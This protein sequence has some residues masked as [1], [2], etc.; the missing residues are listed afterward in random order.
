MYTLGE[1]KNMAEENYIE[2]PKSGKKKALVWLIVLVL[3]AGV[4]VG[5]YFL[6]TNLT[7]PTFTVRAYYG[8]ELV[9]TY[10]VKE[11]KSFDLS[12]ITYEGY[13]IVGIYDNRNLSGEPLSGS[14][15]ITEDVNLFLDCERLYNIR[16]TNGT[17]V[18]NV[19]GKHGDIIENPSV[20]VKEH[21]RFLG[22]AKSGEIILSP[23]LP[24]VIDT[25]EFDG[26]I[27]IL[28]AVWEEAYILSFNVNGGQQIEN[29]Y[30]FS[31]EELTLPMPSRDHYVFTGWSTSAGNILN[32]GDK[33]TLTENI[34]LTAS[35]RE[36]NYTITFDTKGNG[37]VASVQ[38]KYNATI[39]LPQVTQSGMVFIGW[40]YGSQIFNSLNQFTVPDLGDDNVV[41]TFVAYFEIEE[42]TINFNSDGGDVINPFEVKYQEEITLPVVSKEGY[43]FIGWQHNNQ[44]YTGKYTVQDLGEDDASVTFKALWQVE[45]YTISFDGLG[46]QEFEDIQVT[47]GENWD[48]PDFPEIEG[49]NFNGWKLNNTILTGT[50]PDLGNDGDEFTA[51]ADISIKSYIFILNLNGGHFEDSSLVQTLQASFGDEITFPAAVRD[52]YDFMGWGCADKTF[53]GNYIVEDLDD[54]ITRNPNT[55][56]CNAIWKPKTVILT[57]DYGD[58]EV[59]SGGEQKTMSFVVGTSQDTL[60]KP[61]YAEPYTFVGW[62]TSES[63]YVSPVITSDMTLYAIVEEKTSINA[64]G[65]GTAEDPYRIYNSMQLN[66]LSLMGTADCLIKTDSYLKFMQ[67]MEIVRY[68]YSAPSRE[69]NWVLYIDGNDTTLTLSTQLFNIFGGEISNLNLKFNFSYTQDN[70]N[71]FSFVINNR[72]ILDNITILQADYNLS[73]QQGTRFPYANTALICRTNEGTISNCVNNANI[74]ISAV[75]NPEF[76][77]FVGINEGLITNC[78]NHGNI[79]ANG[80]AKIAVFAISNE[81]D[82]T[83]CNSDGDITAYRAGVI[84]YCH[85]T[86]EIININ[87]C[88]ISGSININGDVEKSNLLGSVYKNSASKIYINNI[89]YSYDGLNLIAIVDVTGMA[90]DLTALITDLNEI[91]SSCPNVDFDSIIQKS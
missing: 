71:Y 55:I 32:A 49:Y 30:G 87:N 73:I 50:V 40:Q 84:A 25:A 63:E 65:S 75:K 2:K 5:L 41:V 26:Y 29:L 36:E 60:P 1:D 14:I 24:Y 58:K 44:T 82:I 57:F 86:S 46:Y 22:W 28:T 70:N 79:N 62:S 20:P 19:Y 77:V 48:L 69:T 66:G 33:I 37:A 91:K 45:S 83:Y 88:N 21:A 7:K 56:S 38:T 31:D 39:T 8:S 12:E 4:G 27:L 13:E 17:D 6:I 90:T 51:V 54:Y 61:E 35:W 68:S 52:G 72:G 81:K 18:I 67:D 80:E 53:S 16:L 15:K 47:Y 43:T 10:E 23:S 3:L 89:N 78:D 59:I 64:F 76:A 74:T 85:A 34:T 9:G 11:G 42:Y